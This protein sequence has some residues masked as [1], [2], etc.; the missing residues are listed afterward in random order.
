MTLLLTLPV[1]CSDKNTQSNS[2]EGTT[3]LSNQNTTTSSEISF[4]TN[5]KFNEKKVFENIKIDDILLPSPC[6]LSDFGKDFSFGMNIFDGE[7]SDSGR[8]IGNILHDN[9]KAI[10]FDIYSIKTSEQSNSDKLSQTK[11]DIISQ[12]QDDA[13]S[14]HTLLSV[15]GITVGDKIKDVENALGIPDS[16]SMDGNTASSYTYM[17]SD[18]AARKIQIDFTDGNVSS[19]AIYY[20]VSNN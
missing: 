3:A 14:S 19:I 18:D 2:S 9:N 17:S 16:L 20:N 12:T 7:E 15:N 6:S 10:S 4:N 11:F 8:L 1:G 5:E 13:M